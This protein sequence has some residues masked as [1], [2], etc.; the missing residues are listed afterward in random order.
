M[1]EGRTW[2]GWQCEGVERRF[3]FLSSSSSAVQRSSDNVEFMG[4]Q[5]F[6]AREG[7]SYQSLRNQLLMYNQTYPSYHCR[8]IHLGSQISERMTRPLEQWL[9]SCEIRTHPAL[10]N[11]KYS[12]T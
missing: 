4:N 7:C 2:L 5:K 3:S 1:R 9:S 6:T 12:I 10:A 8:S 11:I